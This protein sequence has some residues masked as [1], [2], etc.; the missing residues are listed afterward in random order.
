MRPRDFEFMFLVT[1]YSFYSHYILSH[2]ASMAT[3][4]LCFESSSK[5]TALGKVFDL[6]LEGGFFFRLWVGLADIAA[7]TEKVFKL[8]SAC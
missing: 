7:S 3:V 5:L 1:D 4:K 2:I 6:L 8:H